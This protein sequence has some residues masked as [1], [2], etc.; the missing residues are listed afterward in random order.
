MLPDVDTPGRPEPLMATKT[1]RLV[2]H[3]VWF[4]RGQGIQ[5]LP[6]RPS[7][8]CLQEQHSSVLRVGRHSAWTGSRKYSIHQKTYHVGSR[9]AMVSL[10]EL[11]ILSAA[12]HE[13]GGEGALNRCGRHLG[14]YLGQSGDRALLVVSRRQDQFVFARRFVYSSR[15]S[16][17]FVVRRWAVIFH[18]TD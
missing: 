17:A 18:R 11:A 8:Y 9:L 15:G 16:S 6:W 10:L 2:F 13:V 1:C 5:L 12:G 4:I 3:R 7:A 14:V